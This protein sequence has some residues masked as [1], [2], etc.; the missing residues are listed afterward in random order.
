[1]ENIDKEFII[2]H[3]E[4]IANAAAFMRSLQKLTKS[5]NP[6]GSL[7]FV[8]MQL[9]EPLERIEHMTDNIQSA[10]K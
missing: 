4:A 8:S 3:C 1:M 10:L 7:H 5:T 6:S 9:E 2:K